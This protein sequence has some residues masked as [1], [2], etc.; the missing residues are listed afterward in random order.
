MRPIIIAVTACDAH[1]YG[2]GGV[3]HQD[4]CCVAVS[5]EVWLCQAEA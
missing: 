5:P 2:R 4:L 3:I 1:A